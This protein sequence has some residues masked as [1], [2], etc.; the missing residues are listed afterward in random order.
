VADVASVIPIPA[1]LD[2]DSA[3]TLVVA[4]VTAYQTLKEAGRIQP[5]DSV[6]IP[7]AAGGVGA[8]AVQLARLFGAGTIIA[9][10]STAEKREQALRLGADHAIDYTDADWPQQVRRLTNGRGADVILEM[11]GGTSFNQ[12]LSALAPFGR[13]VVYGTASRE[14]SNMVP[15]QLLG[16]CQS[17]VG[18]Y[19]A[20]WFA[21]Q[22]QRSL[23][24]FHTIANYLIDGQI[25]VEIGALL[26]LREAGAAHSIIE[27][28]Q[29]SGK[30]VL[31]P[32]LE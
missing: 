17:V 32:W 24:A 26:P 1:E 31:K 15:Q 27:K 21:N 6:F 4:G 25:K 28:R 12:S 16:P 9:S 19:V 20:A 11:A 8:Y 2:F 30:I 3:C 23:E 7:G 13:L 18:Y 5:G 14:R 10:A 22:P 29:A